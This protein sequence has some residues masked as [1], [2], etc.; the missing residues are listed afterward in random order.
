MTDIYT[1]EVPASMIHT[2][3]TISADVVAML[4]Y[5]NKTIGTKTGVVTMNGKLAQYLGAFFFKKCQG[6]HDVWRVYC[7]YFM[8][9]DYF[10][11]TFDSGWRFSLMWMIRFDKGD[12]YLQQIKEEGKFPMPKKEEASSSVTPASPCKEA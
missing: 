2:L 6:S 1:T 11:K 5:W 3:P 10:F 4:D 7:D 8:D 9:K 12:K